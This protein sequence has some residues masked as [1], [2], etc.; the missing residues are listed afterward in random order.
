MEEKNIVKMA[1]NIIMQN[2]KFMS[3]S[4]VTDVESFDEYNVIIF[5]DMGEM[6]VKGKS[7]HINKIDLDS[8]E[9]TLEGTIDSITYSENHTTKASF[10]TKLFR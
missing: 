9:V 1:H 3:V 6:N 10:L 5:T 4:G 2:R 7:L 8:A